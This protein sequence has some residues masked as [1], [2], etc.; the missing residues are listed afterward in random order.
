MG[1][2]S[3]K[4]IERALILSGGGAR[5]AFQVGVIKYLEEIGWKPDLICGTSAGAINATA[6]GSGL[7]VDDMARI[8]QTYNRKL[9][10][11]ITWP[12]F[13]R[14]LLNGRRFA[15]A[16]DTRPLKRLLE[17]NINFAALRHSTPKILITAL[18]MNT[19]Q[20]KFF[21]Q[22]VIGIEHLMA[23]S[24]V[25]LLFPFQYIDGE[26]YWDAGIMINTP[27]RPALAWEA[28]EII[29]VLHSPLGAFDIKTPR[30]RQQTSELAFEHFLIGSYTAMLPTTC[31]MDNPDADVFETPLAGSPQMQLA[32]NGAKLCAVAPKRMLGFRS[33]LNF[34]PTQAN[35]LIKEGYTNARMQLRGMF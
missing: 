30:T 23:A 33:F 3:K 5:G 19:G 6:I 22:K 15:P 16:C 13:F 34:S 4:K 10:Y 20:I 11:R 35:R 12:V 18:N 21:S 17:K 27:I 1:I 28:K 8:W 14:S 9:M 26:P 7:P 32:L 29:V 25:P 24:A 2:N 31:W